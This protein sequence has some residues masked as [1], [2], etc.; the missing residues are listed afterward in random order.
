[1]NLQN[2]IRESGGEGP[3]KPAT[4]MRQTRSPAEKLTCPTLPIYFF[5][6]T[7][8][9]EILL[10]VLSSATS[11]WLL[12]MSDHTKIRIGKEKPQAPSGSYISR[13]VH[14]ETNWTYLG[15]R[16]VATY[17][18]VSEGEHAGKIARRFYPLKKLH[19]GSYEIAPK[20]KLIRD[21]RK[22]FPEQLIEDV[23]DPVA[24]FKDKFFDI[25]VEKRMS[26]S[27]EFNSIVKEIDLHDIGF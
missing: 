3:L 21:I 18:E 6:K 24:L 13:C 27:G 20:S 4:K 5:T 14:V 22:L 17:H 16:K 11:S 12:I 10:N 8:L 26:K 7:P 25:E 23:I 15:N 19:D 9:A 2:N 1:M